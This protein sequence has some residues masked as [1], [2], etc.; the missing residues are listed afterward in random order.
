MDII[1]WMSIVLRKHEPLPTLS[2]DKDS[3]LLIHHSL[4]PNTLTSFI[5]FTTF[6][7]TTC[8]YS[9]RSLWTALDNLHTRGRLKQ[10]RDISG[11]SS[12][13]PHKVEDIDIRN[14]PR[15]PVPSCNSPHTSRRRC[16]SRWLLTVSQ[17]HNWSDLCSTL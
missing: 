10:I 17:V 1:G 9:T 6:V 7:R 14:C 12:N 15:R 8:L 4:F 2:L 16:F 11:H 5:L 3:F 13:R